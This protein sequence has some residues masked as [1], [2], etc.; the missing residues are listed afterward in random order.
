MFNT[1]IRSAGLTAAAIAATLVVAGCN[2]AG[3]NMSPVA[4]QAARAQNDG[5]SADR[6]PDVSLLK[7][8]TKQVVIGSTVDPVNGGQNPYGLTIAPISSGAFTAGDLVVCNFN[9]KSNVQGTGKSLVALHPVP[10]STPT[11][12]SSDKTLTGCDALA[13]GNDDTIW[14]AA[15][16][17]NDNPVIDPGGKLLTNISGK[18][19]SQPW[20][21]IYAEPA[22]SVPAFYET[23]AGTGT[24]VRI[25]LGAT[26]TFDV[27]G[28]GF[29]VNHGKPGTALAPSGLAYD[30]S[31]DTLYF[32][33]GQNDTVI[34]FKNVSTIPNGGIKAVDHGMKFTGPSAA[35]ARI[36]F[37]GAPLNGPIS[38]AL[39]PNGNLVVGN[40]LDADGKNLLIEISAAGKLLDVRNVDKG[41]AGALFGIVASGT[42]NS[43][44][45]IY[46]DDDNDNNVQVLER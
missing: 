41:A 43:N 20:G 33:D 10:N 22:S 46:F 8:L 19:L 25:N 26:F 29:P 15:M 12:V 35:D 40:T 39:L 37:A 3:Q 32:A 14:A 23:N 6:S 36:V 2:G 1:R 4:S 27:I 9:G 16:V 31:V 7:M 17:A 44:T 18:P 28:K 45:K 30:A 42:K 21:Q 11:H 34:A 38:T 13:L 5:S 24:V